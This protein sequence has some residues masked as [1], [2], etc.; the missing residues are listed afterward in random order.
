MNQ[1]AQQ[2]QAEWNAGYRAGLA[3]EQKPSNEKGRSFFGGWLTGK[4]DREA[5]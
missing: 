1:R 3:G 5:Q 4:A 2:A